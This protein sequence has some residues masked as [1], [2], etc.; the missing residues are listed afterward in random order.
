MEKVLRCTN[1]IIYDLRM[2]TEDAWVHY[3]LFFMSV[4]RFWHKVSKRVVIY[5][6]EH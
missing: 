1:N 5:N 2:L 4:K 6:L 3:R